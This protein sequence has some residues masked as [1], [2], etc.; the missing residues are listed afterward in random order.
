[1]LATRA[2]TRSRNVTITARLSVRQ[3]HRLGWI[4]IYRRA[5]ICTFSPFD[6]LVSFS[7]FFP[8]PLFSLPPGQ[9]PQIR[10]LAARCG[11]FF[12]R[13]LDSIVGKEIP[14][15]KLR[16]ARRSFLRPLI[17]TTRRMSRGIMG[18]RARSYTQRGGIVNGVEI[19]FSVARKKK[20]GG[21]KK[22]KN[23][24]CPFIL[25]SRIINAG[26]ASARP[27]MDAAR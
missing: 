9:M 12:A 21:G 24:G 23:Q 15:N 4:K 10:I 14:M 22:K 17:S 13:V 8:R 1:M 19:Q 26:P 25:A 5:N 3:S 20:E 16:A 2:S 11:I 27:W 6:R 18:T 7:F